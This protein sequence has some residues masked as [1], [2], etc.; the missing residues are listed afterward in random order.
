MWWKTLWKLVHQKNKPSRG[1]FRLPTVLLA[2]KL[3]KYRLK[4]PKYI[5]LGTPKNPNKIPKNGQNRFWVMFWG[6]IRGKKVWHKNFFSVIFSVI[7]LPTPPVPAFRIC[8]GCL[9]K[10]EW[11]LLKIGFKYTYFHVFKGFPALK[12]TIAHIQPNGQF[13]PVFGQNG[14]NGGN[15]QKRAWNIFLALTSPN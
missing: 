12:E 13:W 7:F 9:P 14:Q 11:N 4:Q 1:V 3:S 6:K 2:K 10:Y 8:T 15:Y 5:V